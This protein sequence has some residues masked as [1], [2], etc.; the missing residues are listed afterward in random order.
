MSSNNLPEGVSLELFAEMKTA[1]Q[2]FQHAIEPTQQRVAS[3]FVVVSTEHVARAV[4]EER[5]NASLGVR[6]ALIEVLRLG[7]PE[8]MQLAFQSQHLEAEGSVD[9]LLEERLDTTA[10]TQSLSISGELDIFKP[11][12]SN[13][14]DNQRLKGYTLQ[15]VP[16]ALALQLR[17]FQIFKLKPCSTC[18]R[19]APLARQ[20]RQQMSP[21]IYA[22][23]IGAKRKP[24]GPAW[25]ASSCAYRCV[26]ASAKLSLRSWQTNG[27]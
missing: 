6:H 20:Q 18:A 15:N 3:V 4:E 23:Q 27:M 25:L 19:A 22:L 5:T 26:L 1:M 8:Q 21:I 16:R 10:E 9:L 12:A 7:V 2:S 11:F 17:S 13:A 14:G 24:I